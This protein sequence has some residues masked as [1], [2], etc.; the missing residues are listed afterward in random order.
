[1]IKAPTPTITIKRETTHGLYVQVSADGQR[2]TI[3]HLDDHYQPVEVFD[4]P[5]AGN[6][7]LR[8]LVEIT[9]VGDIWD[10]SMIDA[11]LDEYEL[12]AARRWQYKPWQPP[13]HVDFRNL[14]PL[15]AAV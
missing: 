3:A 15:K 9:F 10:M 12:E 2:I 11:L 8:G 6:P 1:M 14:A 4:I 13:A 7:E 5:V